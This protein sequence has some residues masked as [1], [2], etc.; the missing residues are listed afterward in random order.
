MKLELGEPVRAPGQWYGRHRQ[1]PHSAAS[2]E[3]GG[4]RPRRSTTL[5][6]ADLTS[7]RNEIAACSPGGTVIIS[8]EEYGKL[9]PPGEPGGCAREG[10][11]ICR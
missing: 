6:W 8:Y 3:E 11:D 2:Q 10:M 5:M 7:L 9:F 1:V 4:T